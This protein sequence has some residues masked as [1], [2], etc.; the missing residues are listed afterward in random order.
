MSRAASRLLIAVLSSALVLG[1][2][3]PGS[4]DPTST[5]TLEFTIPT[6]TP[7]AAPDPSI[8][9][10]EQAAQVLL[11]TAVEA[12]A[13]GQQE[14]SLSILNAVVE[15]A[16]VGSATAQAANYLLGRRLRDRADF[17]AAVR[18]LE[19][20]AA[21]PGPL[22][23]YASM[24]LGTTRAL[25]G[26]EAEAIS[27]Y[28]ALVADEGSPPDVRD[29]AIT[30]TSELGVGDPSAL[31]DS[32]ASPAALL[33][34]ATALV[35]SSDDADLSG[36]IER[37]L[38]NFPSSEEA[39]EGIL[40]AEASGLELAPEIV[41]LA[42]YRNRKLEEA[43]S[44]LG[45]AIDDPEA[46][47]IVR[48]ERLYYY[49]AAI[50]D[51]G[52]PAASVPLYDQ[53]IAL[54]PGDQFAYR[55]SYWAARALEASGQ[56]EA[57]SSR[58]VT[59]VVTDPGG[60]FAADAAFRAGFVWYEAGQPAEALDVW[61]LTTAG[62]DARVLYWM[63]RAL[64]SAGEHERAAALYEDAAADSASFYGE[65][66]QRRLTGEPVAYPAYSP[67]PARPTPDWPSVET[68][69]AGY[70]GITSPVWGIAQALASY[71]SW[72][73]AR[74]PA[75]PSKQLR[76]PTRAPQPYLSWRAKHPRRASPPWRRHFCSEH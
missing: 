55:A 76:F 43:A 53:V 20:A 13:E 71:S 9:A 6:A 2:S 32:A 12:F 28:D 42:Y 68:W 45:P 4:P 5:P 17:P 26:D 72:A 35:D 56:T 34:A 49:A 67:L 66:A 31:L 27:I 30:A 69:L 37:L 10:A 65:E 44:V 18:H 75:P 62:A 57:A 64:E 39:L 33:A 15:A 14:Q 24:A 1:C 7:T 38:R 70:P 73:L 59:L 8:G 46:T 41:G 50:D 74:T 16:P 29:H 58:Y 21:S 11:G 51:A 23:P 47:P 52:D 25:M 48:A 22:S 63:A 60:S 3:S 40:L 54:V 36:V 19:V 61:I